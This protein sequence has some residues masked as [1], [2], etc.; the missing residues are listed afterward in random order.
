[1]IMLADC[2]IINQDL[3]PCIADGMMLERTVMKAF[4]K[5][6]FPT[7]PCLVIYCIRIVEFEG[8]EMSCFSVSY[9]GIHVML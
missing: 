2:A 9:G 4:A 6:Y 7:Y 1:M 3:N 5:H 8:L